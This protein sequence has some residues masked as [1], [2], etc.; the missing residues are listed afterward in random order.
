MAPPEGADAEQSPQRENRG[1]TEGEGP[2]CPQKGPSPGPEPRSPAA[3]AP[4][5]SGQGEV[6]L[7]RSELPLG[8]PGQPL[9]EHKP[10]AGGSGPGQPAPGQAGPPPASLA[11]GRAAGHGLPGGDA[12]TAAGWCPAVPPPLWPVFPAGPGAE[13]SA[14]RLPAP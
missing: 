12:G 1:R 5:H 2:R 14:P 4:A 10:M 13:V 6:P 8:R 3:A 9:Q 7:G 11:A